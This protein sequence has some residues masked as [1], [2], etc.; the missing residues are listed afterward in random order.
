MRK[1]WLLHYPEGVPAEI[2]ASG[3]ASLAD[4]LDQA[5]IRHASLPALT[6]MGRSLTYA[7]LDRYSAAVAAWLQGL[8]LAQGSR[9]ALMMPNTLVN[10]VAFLGVVRA[11][12]VVVNVNPLYSAEE[13]E[14]QLDDCGADVIFIFESSLATLDQVSVERRPGHVVAVRVGDLMGAKGGV[15]NFVVRHV[16]RMVPSYQIR[17][18][19]PFVQVLRQG[20]SRQWVRP[21]HDLDAVAVLQYTGGT[22]GVPKG[23]MLTHRNLVSNVLQIDAV[24]RPVLGDER[25]RGMVI[26]TALPLYH[27]FA[28]TVC[29]L[30]AAHA[31]MRSVL[32]ADPRRLDTVV[33][34]W[35]RNPVHIFPS[36][37]TLFNA[38]VNTPQFLALDFS[39]LRLCFGG[40]AAVQ[41]AVADKWQRATGRPI[42]EGYGLTESSPVAIVNPTNSDSY[43]GD[44]G[45]PL[46][47]TDVVVLD[48]HDRPLPAGETG[49]LAIRGPQVMKGYWRRQDETELA[50][51]PEGFLRTGDIAVIS[52]Q[53]RVRIVDRKK[54]MILVSGF[55]VYP[56]EVEQV[57]ARHPGVLECVAVGAPSAESGEM[58]KLY[59][60]RKDPGLTQEALRDWCAGHLTPYKRP[61]V[62][63]FRSELPKSNT[64][65]ILRR[66][67]RDEA[68]GQSDG[69]AR[70]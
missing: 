29:G 56:N 20:R 59:V 57:V 3:I 34:A 6:F 67:L 28:M 8:G 32:I 2:D 63:V 24:A 36:V 37:N 23:A 39:G 21:E 55:N 46:P 40:G 12:M 44:I 66:V 68:E 4:M 17:G 47:S 13:L 15:I 70:T 19:V 1:P 10:M 41:R 5:C 53:G 61:H 60:V 18:V 38:L 62:I 69:A 64:G 22:T 26:M 31:G 25:G 11:G 48:D 49:E 65:K 51:T 35:R 58:V 43:S 50:F 54:D 42:I 30:F 7:E 52:E 9:V 27:V 14:H 45:F 33:A 16:K